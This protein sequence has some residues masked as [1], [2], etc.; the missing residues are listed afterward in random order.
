MNPLPLRI[1][2]ESYTFLCMGFS[3][4]LVAFA[5]ITITLEVLGQDQF[6]CLFSEAPQAYK[7]MA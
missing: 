4:P 1:K 2:I 6:L 5:A 7:L 3:C